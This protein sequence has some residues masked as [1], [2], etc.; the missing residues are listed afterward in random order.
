M[1]KKSWIILTIVIFLLILPATS[2]DVTR[3]DIEP[4]NPVKG[5]KVALTGTAAPEEEVKI[6]I[7]FQ[8]EVEV[9]DGEYSFSLH[10]VKILKGDNK[11]TV[12]AN[13]CKDLK[14]SV[15]KFFLTFTFG[16]EATNGTARISKSAPSG[17]YDINIHGN[18]VNEKVNLKII[19]TTY[20]KADNNGKFTYSYDTSS[21]P[22]GKFV[23]TAGSK[24]EE[25]TLLAQP[26]TTPTPTPTP[27]STLTPSQNSGSSS[28][29]GGS[30]GITTTSTPEKTI[31]PQETLTPQTTHIPKQSSTV[32]P[33][34]STS[35]TDT[36][37]T[38]A[39]QSQTPNETVIKTGEKNSNQDIGNNGTT[40]FQVPGFGVIEGLV[41]LAAVLVF[42]KLC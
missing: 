39:P 18:S 25:V 31:T 12:I 15:M 23:V 24:K 11:F 5:E 26:P 22:P 1:V 33:S 38:Q 21:I 4:Q 17:T 10:K 9:Q 28:S 16:S 20:L 29:G 41:V 30:S 32:N 40:D 37:A 2:A 3:L 36:I 19:A 7:S 6:D 42:R 14:V 8:Q 34:G 27:T 13:N 35:P